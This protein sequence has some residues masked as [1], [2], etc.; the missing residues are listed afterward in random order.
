[1]YLKR[2]VIS[3]LLIL[4]FY[5][6]A[7]A[8]VTLRQKIGQMVIVTFTGDSLEKRTASLDTLKNDLADGLIGGVTYYTWSNNLKNPAQITRLSGQLQQNTKIPLLIA[9]DQEGGSVAR[10]SGSNGFQ[11]S[12]TAYQLGTIINREDS[13]RAQSALMAGWLQ[14]SGINT[15]YAPDA[16]VDVNPSSPAIGALG[17]SFSSKPDSVAAH[18]GWFID[19]M[20]RKNII[21][22][23]KHFPGHGSA[24]TDSHLGFTDISTT[25]T[26]QELVPFQSIISNR[27][28]DIIMMGHL[29]N[30]SLDSLYPASLSYNIVTTILRKQLGFDGVIITDAMNMG[31]ITQNYG[32][33]QSI[34]L[35][36]KAGVNLLLYPANFDSLNRSL[37]RTIV[38][39]IEKN[40]Q[41]GVIPQSCIDDSYARIMNLKTKYLGVTL[42][43]VEGN[44]NLPIT[45]TI[46]NYPNPFNIET[47]LQYQVPQSGRIQLRIFDLLG[48]VVSVL[49]D[50]VAHQGVYTARWNAS[51]CASGVYIAVLTTPTNVVKQKLVLLK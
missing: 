15:D 10:L 9:T 42:V 16:D 25:W 27:T 37:A 45:C 31:A 51:S 8:Q 47:I 18:V 2:C 14:Q 40:V 5:F 32:F 49:K 33:E 39:L 26:T 7:E 22:T 41:S 6:F 28:A 4:S 44:S 36:V 35:A 19:E 3:I 11:S 38:G 46:Q 20:H 1:M 12:K 48:R 43:Y 17:R 29:F 34:I 21:T 50:E 13:T 23:V 24:A 30:R